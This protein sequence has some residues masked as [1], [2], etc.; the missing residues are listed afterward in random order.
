[1][2]RIARL[3]PLGL[4]ESVRWRLPRTPVALADRQAAV[5]VLGSVMAYGLVMKLL[6][7]V[8]VG[9]LIGVVLMFEPIAA[10]AILF[11]A[12]IS[13]AVWIIRASSRD[14]IETRLFWLLVAGS[15]AWLTFPLFGMFKQVVLPLRGFLWDRSLAHIGRML[16]G[17]SPWQVTH[18]V[19]GSLPATRFLD[20]IYSL[21]LILIFAFPMVVAVVFGDPR[22]R[23]RLIFS[24]FAA[25]V[26]IGTLAAWV[27][28]SA[29][30][31]YFNALVGHD[32]NYAAL[33]LR[34][35]GLEHLAEAQ[36]RPIAALEFQPILLNAFRLRDYAPAGGI[37]AM[38]SMHVAL[39]T[40]LVIGGFQHNRL[41]GALLATY[42]LL[43]WIASI[44]FGWHYFIDGPV[45]ALM[46]LGLW[47][48]SAPLAARLYPAP[49][50]SPMTAVQG[51][52][53]P[54][55]SPPHLRNFF[56][57]TWKRRPL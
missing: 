24:W 6:S 48:A 18:S 43:I 35:A 12:L 13:V 17:V 27:F 10:A 20:S 8:S 45:A 29:G 3:T 41:W 57:S 14:S 51:E 23:F 28:A 42:A 49:S 31:V 50:S 32:A 44:H 30:P 22:V 38:P 54:L 25:W 52:L 7:G 21:W 56:E 40:L 4:R 47:R 37:S 16:L 36:G 33:Q 39:A 11:V 1:M 9:S 46:M 26:V 19:F 55:P 34:L 2:T 15:M 53:S 5:V